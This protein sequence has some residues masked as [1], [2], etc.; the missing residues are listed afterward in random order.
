M[1]TRLIALLALI[2]LVIGSETTLIA[3]TYGITLNTG[4]GDFYTFAQSSD[5]STIGTIK[6][7]APPGSEFALQGTINIDGIDYLKVI[8]S[9]VPCQ[10]NGNHLIVVKANEYVIRAEFFRDGIIY[11]RVSAL[12]TGPLLVPFKYRVSGGGS[13]SAEASV[14]LYFGYFVKVRNARLTFLG[15]LGATQIS[16]PKTDSSDLETKTALTVALGVVLTVDS[17]MQIGI[18]IGA[19]TIGGNSSGWKHNGKLWISAAIG[20]RFT[21]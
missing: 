16:I 10:E 14:G 15:T 7:W 4:F 6:F 17:K 8:F 5:G 11:E 12:E 2:L 20:F 18:V 1:Y 13:I 19:D 9:K 3:D 21:K